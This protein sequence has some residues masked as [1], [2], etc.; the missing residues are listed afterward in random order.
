MSIGEGLESPSHI[1]IELDL[2]ALLSMDTATQTKVVADAVRAG[3][4]SPNENMT[5]SRHWVVYRFTTLIDTD[6]RRC[7]EIRF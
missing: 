4:M 1:G 7:N 5:N 3:I 6:I 2:E